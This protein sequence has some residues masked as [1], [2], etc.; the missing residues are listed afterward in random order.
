MGCNC[1]KG[2]SNVRYAVTFSD[3]KSQTYN[4]VGEAQAA[5]KATQKP[6]T[7]KAVPA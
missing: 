4:T 7:F 6:Y 5:G 2:K 1:G 3:G